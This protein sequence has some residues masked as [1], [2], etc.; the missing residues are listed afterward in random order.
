L[1]NKEICLIFEADS[2]PVRTITVL[3]APYSLPEIKQEDVLSREKLVY[4]QLSQC[5]SI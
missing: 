3:K 2:V 1:Q 5:L 4:F